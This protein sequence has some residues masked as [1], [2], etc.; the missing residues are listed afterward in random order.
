[1]Y[2][3]HIEITVFNRGNKIKNRVTF[4]SLIIAIFCHN[5]KLFYACV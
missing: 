3:P 4:C 1:M 2:N 5:H